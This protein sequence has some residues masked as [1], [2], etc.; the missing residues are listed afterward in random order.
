MRKIK[1]ASGRNLLQGAAGEGDVSDCM[2][3]ENRL[4]EW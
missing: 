1:T 3:T 2:K 4:L